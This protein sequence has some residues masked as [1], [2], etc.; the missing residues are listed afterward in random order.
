M[1]GSPNL[2]EAKKYWGKIATR[3]NKNCAVSL[4]NYQSLLYK[5]WLQFWTILIAK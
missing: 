1:V 4:R 3:L 5:K 2:N